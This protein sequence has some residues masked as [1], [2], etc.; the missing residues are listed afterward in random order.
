MK[1]LPYTLAILMAATAFAADKEGERPKSDKELIQGTWEV[2]S[3]TEGGR[4][5]DP[6]GLRVVFTADLMTFKPKNAKG[7]K[8]TRGL[9]YTL[10]PAKTP[11]H[12]DTSHRLGP[13]EKP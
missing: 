4:V 7:P 8:D 13:A 9:T 1:C 10:D 12:I 6:L 2:V 3:A 11:K 5:R